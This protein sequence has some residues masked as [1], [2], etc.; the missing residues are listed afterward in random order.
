MVSSPVGVIV[1]L[2]GLAREQ[3]HWGGFAE[4]LRRSLGGARIR[5]LDLAG[6]G[7]EHA[8]RSPAS[9]EALMADCRARLYAAGEEAPCRLVGL[10]LG[11]MVATAWMD[12][13]PVE[14][15]AAVLINT[16]LRPFSPFWRRMQPAGGCRLLGTLVQRPEQ[17]ERSI[18]ALT[19]RAPQNHAAELEQWIALRRARP[20]S[21]PNALRQL[22]AAVVSGRAA[23]GWEPGSLVSCPAND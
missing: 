12:A 7:S 10:S 9:V 6:N 22:V 3:G 15:T 23:R 1:L 8:T 17:A 5:A 18:L 2:R 11:A 19:S 13:H 4:T 14:V 20:V 16:S 21:S